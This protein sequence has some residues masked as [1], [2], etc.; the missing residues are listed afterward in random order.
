ME[1]NEKEFKKIVRKANYKRTGVGI[2]LSLLSFILISTIVA[3]GV[4]IHFNY[5]DFSNKDNPK[6]KGL[7]NATMRNLKKTD[8]FL[9]LLFAHN[10]GFEINNDKGKEMTVF[11]DYY[12]KGELKKHDEVFSM[13]QDEQ[14]NDMNGVFHWGISEDSKKLSVSFDTLNGAVMKSGYDL[15]EL[16]LNDWTGA[17]F[18]MP[19]ER[20][21]ELPKK[22]LLAKFVDNKDGSLSS[23]S[24]KQDEFKSERIQENDRLILFYVEFK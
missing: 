21:S 1:F 8:G 9:D 18:A 23:Y 4:L 13:I 6:V 2:V 12:E 22:H 19:G 16:K 10:G 5:I 15:T 17:S 20:Q 11:L 7:P 14:K 24:D 3:L